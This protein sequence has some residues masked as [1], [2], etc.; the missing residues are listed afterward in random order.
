MLIRRRTRE[1]GSWSIVCQTRQP[2]ASVVTVLTVLYWLLTYS[3]RRV[4]ST[5]STATP[6]IFQSL[7][8]FY[9]GGGRAT[10][11]VIADRYMYI[12]NEYCRGP[13][14]INGYMILL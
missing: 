1:W 9:M 14:I 6:H 13:H 11:R 5:V 10:R 3:Q 7:L 4:S 8:L 12:R 2:L